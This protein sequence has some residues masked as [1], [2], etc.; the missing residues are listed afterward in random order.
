MP[1]PWEIL[2]NRTFQCPG[3]PS[4]PVSMERVCNYLLS[5]KQVQKTHLDQAHGAREL[6]ELGPS[7]EVL[8]GFPADDE[9]IPRTIM[10]KA[11]ESCS[12]VI[13]AQGKQFH[14]TREHMGPIHLNIPTLKAPKQQPP[15]P[16]IN[17]LLPRH[18]LKPNS[19]LK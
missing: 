10:D 2:H 9:Y 18:I 6:P 13:E 4:T 8:F 12:Y 16:N 7:Q 11:T 1:S 19:N 17:R 14:R 15:K 5:K 3:K